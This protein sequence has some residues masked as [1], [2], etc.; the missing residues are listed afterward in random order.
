MLDRVGESAAR[1]TE[2]TEAQT[3]FLSAVVNLSNDAIVTKA[4]DGTITSWN[5]SASR[6][7]GYE[8]EEIIGRSIRL[9]IP[10]EL[11]AEEDEILARLRAGEYIEHYETVRLTQDGQR[12]DVSL[13]ISPIKNRWGDVTGATKIARD[14]TARKLADEQLISATAKFESVFNQSG[15]F[16]GILDLDGYLREIN[17]LAVD[18]CGYSR[19][20][21]LDRPFWATRWWRGSTDVQD[22]IRAATQQAARG[23]VF[24]ETLHYWLAD[25]SERI[26]DFAMHPIRDSS[27]E[28]RFLHPTGLDI[29]D[30]TRAEEALKKREAEEREIALGLQRALLPA[31]LAVP[32]GLSVAGRY[33]AGS[34]AMEVGGDWYDVFPL[35]NGTI[36]LT[37]GDVVGHGLAA[38]AAMGQLRTAISAF[39]Q[40]TAGPGE[41]VTRLD[42]FIGR[43]GAT[44]FATVCY[45]VL[46]PMNGLLEYSSAG[47]PPI[48]LVRPDGDAS[49]LNEAQSPPLCGDWHQDRPYAKIRLEPGSLVV[50]Y[51]DGLVER[52]GE[53][54]TDSLSRLIAAGASLAHVSPT[55]VCDQLISAF[56]RDAAATDDVAV[57][58]VRFDPDAR[59]CFHISF[60]ARPKE[61]RTLRQS[62][63]SWLEVQEVPATA[64]DTV[65]LAVGEACTNAIEHAY[66]QKPT[67]EVV[68]HV[69]HERDHTLR[70][71]VRDYGHYRRASD[72]L[73]DR[74]RGTAI[75]KRLTTDFSRNSTSAGTTVQFR[76]PI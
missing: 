73:S 61:L 27:G 70:V 1:P 65:L 37:I 45:G 22:R 76:L 3:A 4:L 47:H 57:L 60:P 43:T 29:T 64:R 25:G 21:V 31:T 63:R 41:L 18:W 39:A 46:D 71:V 17:A 10:D 28:V 67:G 58:A 50:F 2:T 62:L 32:A 56:G 75:M 19:E 7:F 55:D 20:D 9:L 33:E 54:L 11:Q 38:A 8:P 44:D 68:V 69:D 35:A 36:A 16:A 72:L 48:L 14:I 53:L 40:F 74:G 30:R 52:R 51:S 15:I 59:G 42:R 49:W 66:L 13:S 12:V 26:V 5:A 34:A 6:I 23:E 24:R